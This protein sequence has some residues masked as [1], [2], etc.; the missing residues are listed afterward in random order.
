M[1]LMYTFVPPSLRH[2]GIAFAL[3]KFVLEYAREANLKIIIGC[4]TISKFIDLHPEYE[5][6]IDSR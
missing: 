6:L 3:V 4:S 1:A 2:R 5:T